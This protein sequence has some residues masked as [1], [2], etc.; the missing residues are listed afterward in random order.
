MGVAAFLVWRTGRDG[1]APRAA[2]RA[3]LGLF[4][5]QLVLNGVWTPVFF[6]AES[7]ADGAIVISALVLVLALTARAFFGIRRWA[8]WLLVPYLGWVAYAAA[9]NLAIWALN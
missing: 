7:I 2:V 9:L 1:E 6:G 3:A 8:G 5:A 4:V